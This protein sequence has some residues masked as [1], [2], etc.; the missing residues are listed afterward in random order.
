MARTVR[1]KSGDR[2][3]MKLERDYEYR[4][5]YILSYGC[6][7]YMEWWNSPT[8]WFGRKKIEKKFGVRWERTSIKVYTTPKQL[9]VKRIN[10]V[11]RDKGNYTPSRMYKEAVNN[12]DRACRKRELHKI[13]KSCRDG[14]DDIYEY[15]DSY[16]NSVQRALIWSIW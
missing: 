3:W 12:S 11:E 1:R 14:F 15:D 16:E 9:D 8:D 13:M 6:I 7:N 5:G 10:E 2:P 4:T